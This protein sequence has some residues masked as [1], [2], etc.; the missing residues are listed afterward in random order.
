MR[1]DTFAQDSAHKNMHGEGFLGKLTICIF[2]F[3]NNTLRK[4]NKS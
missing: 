2:R 3:E 4:V 1:S